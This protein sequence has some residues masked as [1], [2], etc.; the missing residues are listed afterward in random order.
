VGDR[1]DR[2][3]PA[4]HRCTLPRDDLPDRLGEWRNL[5]AK[6]CSRTDTPDGATRLS[7]GPDV[8]IGTLARLVDEEHRCCGFLSFSINLDERGVSLDMSA[9][10]EDRAV[11]EAL[12]G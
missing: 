12:L 1:S 11:L 9:T 5:L 7:F 4:D 10:R 2:S 8:E 6:A 3:T